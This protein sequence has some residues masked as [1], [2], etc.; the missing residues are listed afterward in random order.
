[1]FKALFYALLKVGGK[2]LNK[3]LSLL[4][5]IIYLVVAYKTG[6]S[7]SLVKNLQ[8]LILPMFC[9][10]FGKGM[11]MTQGSSLGGVFRAGYMKA[12]PACIVVF[13]GWVLLLIP[14]FIFLYQVYFA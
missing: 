11:G 1:M 10:W 7:A 3:A 14:L 5:A 2:F 9:I 12:S 4:I 8:F 6:G 13:M